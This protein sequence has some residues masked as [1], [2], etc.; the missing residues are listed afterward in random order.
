MGKAHSSTSPAAARG[1]AKQLGDAM[2]ELI[3][4]RFRALG[5]P[6]RLKIL[7]ILMQGEQTVSQLVETCG[8]GQ[9]NISKHLSVLKDAG[10]V[11]TRR[12]GLHTFCSISDP[13]IFQLCELMCA[14]LKAEHDERAR[15]FDAL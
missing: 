10:M 6:L 8:S 5:E 15:Q 7:N 9:A 2:L 1:G 3:A 14:K 13:V 4:S 12:Q 11:G